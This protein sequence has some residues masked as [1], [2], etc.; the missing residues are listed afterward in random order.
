M[1]KLKSQSPFLGEHDQTVSPECA[2]LLL[3]LW[4]RSLRPQ[5]LGSGFCGGWETRKPWTLCR[6]GGSRNLCK[7]DLG[8]W[9]T[10]RW[11]CFRKKEIRDEA[12]LRGLGW[13]RGK[14]LTEHYKGKMSTLPAPVKQRHL[15]QRSASLL[16]R[17]FPFSHPCRSAKGQSF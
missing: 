3:L 7:L 6:K 4:G 9:K 16:S 2:R 17:A 5:L 10:R 12:T 15:M 14:Q 11:W 1:K 8:M 13:E